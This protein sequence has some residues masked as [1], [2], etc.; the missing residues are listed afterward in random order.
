MK[1]KKKQRHHELKDAAFVETQWIEPIHNIA[2]PIRDANL[3]QCKLYSDDNKFTP[4]RE[5]KKTHQHN[6]RHQQT[7]RV[8]ESKRGE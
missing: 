4:K 3:K 1:A 7:L 2:A 8:H 6:F 5:N